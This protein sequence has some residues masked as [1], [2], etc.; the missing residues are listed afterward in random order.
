MTWLVRLNLSPRTL[1][2]TTGLLDGDRLHRTLMRLLPDDLGE[3]PRECGGLLYRIEPG[4][5]GVGLLAQTR[6]PPRLAALPAELAAGAR[7]RDLRPLLDSLRPGVR[8]RYRIVANATRR[9]GNSAEQEKRGKLKVLR[10]TEADLWWLRKAT[11]AGL[12]PLQ[13]VSSPVDDVLGA[14]GT[15]HG[16]TRFDGVG[17]VTD[18]DLLR[19]AVADGIGRAKTYG[20]GM[21]SLG[22]ADAS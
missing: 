9:H 11:A 10:G 2:V 20:C 8:V 14:H 6:Q 17:M 18:A 5:A 21:L 22:P 16:L 3:R 15:R 19:A 7:D 13:V 1:P 4:R 12:H